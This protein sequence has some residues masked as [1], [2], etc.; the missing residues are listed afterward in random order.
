[1]GDLCW[2]HERGQDVMPSLWE[3]TSSVAGEV[4]MRGGK[5]EDLQKGCPTVILVR[6]VVGRVTALLCSCHLQEA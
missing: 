2:G 1:M 5:V 6:L 4:E 3:Y